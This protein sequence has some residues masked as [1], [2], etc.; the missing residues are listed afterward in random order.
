M[1]GLVGP[2][3]KQTAITLT[4]DLPAGAAARLQSGRGAAKFV[5]GGLGF[6]D[7]TLRYDL[8]LSALTSDAPPELQRLFRAIASSK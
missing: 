2:F 7:N 5:V 1:G 6:K 4:F 3:S 8:P